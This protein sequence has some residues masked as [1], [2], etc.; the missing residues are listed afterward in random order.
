MIR[1]EITSDDGTKLWLL[2]SQVHHAEVS[3]EITTHWHEPFSAEVVDAIT[4]HDDGWADWEA[5]PT[6]NPESGAPYSFLEMPLAESLA[7][8]DRS[9]ASARQFG[10]LAGYVV[11]GHFYNLLHESEH[12]GEGPA[13]AWLTAKRKVRTAWI[14]E[15]LRADTSHKLENAKRAQQMIGVADLFSL[16]LCCECP[17]DGHESS[18]LAESKMKPRVH[19]LSEQYQFVVQDF[20]AGRSERADRLTGYA[21]TVSVTPYPFGDSLPPMAVKAIATPVRRYADWQELVAAGWAVELKW[22]LI[23]TVP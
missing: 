21:W 20:L 1:R 3:G 15:W 17:I 9:I 7:I 5:Q 12:A 11:A 6:L 13:I 14:D 22:Q 8:W 10:P 16:W 2:I 4:H 23:P 18:M 19:T